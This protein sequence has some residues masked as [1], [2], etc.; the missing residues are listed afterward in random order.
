[1]T[2]SGS[3][4][5][6]GFDTRAEIYVDHD[7]VRRRIHSGHEDL[8]RRVLEICVG[9]RLFDRGIVRTWVE[10]E[11][12]EEIKFGKYMTGILCL[13]HI[14][15]PLFLRYWSRNRG[16][17]IFPFSLHSPPQPAQL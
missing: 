2:D 7:K 1:M 14:S 17:A 8:Y 16:R 6:K 12:K 3:L 11:G 13:V 4:V 15:I 9:G 10:G 5:F